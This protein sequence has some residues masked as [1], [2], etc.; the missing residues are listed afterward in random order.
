M[1][2]VREATC[3]RPRHGQSVSKPATE[4]DVVVIGSGINGL[5]AAVLLAR[6]GCRVTVLERN[7]EPGGALVTERLTLPGYVHDALAS[8]HGTFVNGPVWPLLRDELTARGVRYHAAD[9][10]VTATVRRDGSS[11]LLHRDPVVTAAGLGA[12][13]GPYLAEL[14]RIRAVGPA[15]GRL[16]GGE[17]VPTRLA[18]TAA[19][20]LAAVGPT[21]TVDLTRQ[22]LSGGR[23]WAA[24]TFTGS[25]V[26]ALVAPWLLHAG[27][28]P[29]SASGGLTGMLLMDGL[30]RA[31]LPVAEGGSRRLVDALCALLTDLGGRLEVG[32]DATRIR[33]GSGRATGVAVADGREFPARRAVLA[34]VTPQALYAGLLADEPTVPSRIRSAAGRFRYGRSAMQLHVAL[35]APLK[36]NDPRLASV[37]LV[38][39]SDGGASVALACAQAEAGLLPARPTV[40]V[41]Q[42]HVLDPSRVPAGAAALWIQLQELPRHPTGDA[43][44]GTDAPVD[45]WTPDVV[46]RYVD[47]VLGMVTEH[48]PN[49]DRVRLASAVLTPVDLGRRNVNFVGGDPYSG[50]AALDQALWWRPIPSVRGHRTVVDGLWHIGASTH[51]GAGLGGLSGYAAATA[52]LRRRR[53]VSTLRDPD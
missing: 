3:G 20:L 38:H 49:L 36:W 37:P 30:H 6:A 19:R 45:G 2:D 51:P 8:W 15:L 17:A 52:L 9:D 39:L 14:R 7:A 29:D 42:Q 1:D 43:A 13:G 35:S 53:R 21:G 18:A 24:R 46:Q 27:L 22:A 32:A 12:D 4:A 50:S 23:A 11:V 25:D 26:D 16:L 44:G 41:G 34:C 40:V 33:V 28:A 47:R 5:V 48:A 31:G 10:V